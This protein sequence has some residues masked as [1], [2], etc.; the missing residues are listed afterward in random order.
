MPNGDSIKACSP[1]QRE[2]EEAHFGPFSKAEGRLKQFRNKASKPLKAVGGVAKKVATGGGLAIA[3][4]AVAA[5]K[6]FLDVGEELDKMS[7]RTGISVE[8]LGELKFAAEQSGSSIETVEKA[9]KRMA[10]TIF[11]ATD[12]VKAAEDALW[13]LGLSYDDFEGLSPEEQFLE[14]GQALKEVSD[15]T[16]RAALAQKIFG[17]AGT[18]LLPLF[19]EG[20]TGMQKLR[21]QAKSLGI[22]MSGDAAAGAA[23]FND[24][25]NELKQAFLG[26][27][28]SLASKLLPKLSEFAR[29]LVSK[30][31]EVVDF[32]EKVKE[33]V[34]PFFDAFMTGIDTV[35]PVIKSFFQWVFNNKPVL[36]AAIVAIGVA[37]A[38]TLG[39]VSLA[40]LAIVALITTIGWVRDNWDQIWGKIKDIFETVVNAIT[41][42]FNTKWVWLMPGGALI[43]A[44]QF[45]RDNWDTIWNTIKTAFDTITST[46]KTLY[47]SNLGWLLPGGALI[48]AVIFVKDEWDRIWNTIKTAFDT[49]TST[50]KTL[51]TSNLGWL[52]PGGALIKAVIFV[53]DE[54]DR[55]WGLVRSTWETISGK[56]KELYTSNLGWLLPGGALI[57]AIIFVRKEWDRIWGLIKIA[58][59]AMTGAIEKVYNKT[60]G[61]VFGSD[62]LLAVAVGALRDKWNNIWGGIREGFDGFISPVRAALDALIGLINRVK[63]AIRSIPSVP[64]VG[65]I[66]GGVKKVGGGIKS[67]TGFGGSATTP[68]KYYDGPAEGFAKGV[69]NF[70]GG[71]ALVGE[72]GPELV[73]LPKG[74]NVT[75]NNQMGGSTVNINFN[76]PVYGV[77]DFN[78]KVNQARLAWERA[79][80]G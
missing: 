5:V 30:K 54:W 78:E 66:A 51:Y 56:I 73:D 76:G 12:G 6:N 4:F 72:E 70:R 33:A 20:F 58:W 80:N 32:F 57:K 2:Y 3:G 37:I 52:L 59:D 7:K 18:E 61:K 60:L 64:G 79:G 55:I 65:K 74:S 19:D 44:I 36:I 29:W 77:D 42:F 1:D 14:L 46:I 45:L 75:P 43:K 41:G 26:A 15:E 10:A 23:D 22:V 16:T 11:D 62:G 69:R 53:K 28:T 68:P 49:I 50:I 27:F 9:T 63:S 48:K 67:F 71:R 39:P 25:I 24:S 40:V 21:D 47:T 8:S 31:P 38:T 13:A 35:W 17:K 34:T